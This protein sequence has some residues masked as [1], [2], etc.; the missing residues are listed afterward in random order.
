MLEKI[1]RSDREA[2]YFINHHQKGRLVSLKAYTEEQVASARHEYQQFYRLPNGS[3]W[4]RHRFVQYIARL[5]KMDGLFPKNVVKNAV[6]KG[7]VP[8]GFDVHHHIPLSLGGQNFVYN[9]CL[10]EKKAHQKMHKFIWDKIY[11]DMIK[12][13]ILNPQMRFYVLLPDLPVVFGINDLK[14][15]LSINELKSF[16]IL[17]K[18]HRSAELILRSDCIKYLPTRQLEPI[19]MR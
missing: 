8:S 5:G 4:P 19:F 18:P 12:Q 1:I 17:R 15:I 6:L 10:I 7:V 16:P 13:S 3:H 2:Y 9:M 14:M 11:Q